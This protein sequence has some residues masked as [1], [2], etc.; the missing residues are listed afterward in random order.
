MGD[1][2]P[3]FVGL[4]DQ[5]RLTVRLDLT[6]I[7]RL[8][9]P[10]EQVVDTRRKLQEALE[11]VGLRNRRADDNV[12]PPV[13]DFRPRPGPPHRRHYFFPFLPPS[14]GRFL[15]RFSRSSAA[16]NSSRTESETVTSS[17][18]KV[19]SMSIASLESPYSTR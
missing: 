9:P 18:S 1:E 10:R 16:R 5:D 15:A 7:R 19:L 6:V 11:M 17:F 3:L 2:L 13:D 8:I 12:L 14:T 4:L